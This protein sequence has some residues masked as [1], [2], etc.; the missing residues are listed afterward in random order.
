[1]SILIPPDGG[2]FLQRGPQGAVIKI[3]GSQTAG[4]LG[5]IEQPLEVGAMIRPHI[6]DH[7]VWL[8][9]LEGEVGV[10]VGNETVIAKPRSWVL[11]PRNIM[12]AM[13]NA[14]SAEARVMEAFT[15]AGF[16]EFMREV[17]QAKSM[18]DLTDERFSQLCGQYG[19]Q[20]FDDWTGDE[21]W[22][23]RTKKKYGVD[24]G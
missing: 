21:G 23:E 24:A 18:N 7:D 12:H 22:M 6:H 11:K 4:N 16:E 17:A 9:V 1:V 3:D 14:G 10:R 13:W 20:F 2:D 8:Q 19:I 15:P 5:V